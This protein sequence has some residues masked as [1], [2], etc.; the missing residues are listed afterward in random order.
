[1]EGEVRKGACMSVLHGAASP[2]SLP[3]HPLNGLTGSLTAIR[4]PKYLMYG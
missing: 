1:M 2:L 4:L 3:L